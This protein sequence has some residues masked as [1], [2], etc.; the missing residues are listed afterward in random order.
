MRT[1]FAFNLAREEFE[2]YG[3][4]QWETMLDEIRYGLV[5]EGHWTEEKAEEAQFFEVLESW[6]PEGFFFVEEVDAPDSV[7]LVF[8][9]S[10]EDLFVF[11]KESWPTVVDEFYEKFNLEDDEDVYEELYCR[12]IYVGFAQLA[13]KVSMA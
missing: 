6:Y 11:S 12:G 10:T 13:W 2:V 8:D 9:K 4:E 7:A 1:Y 5:D 3:E